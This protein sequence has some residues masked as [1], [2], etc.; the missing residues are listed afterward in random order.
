MGSV[1]EMGKS[2]YLASKDLGKPSFGVLY[3]AAALVSEVAIGRAM[4][5]ACSENDVVR[6]GQWGSVLV[7]R[8]GF[9][10]SLPG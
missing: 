8:S 9:A 4:K 1:T 7:R 10:E 3:L 5:T 6:T 2:L